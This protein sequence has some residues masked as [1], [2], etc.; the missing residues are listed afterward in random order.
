MRDDNHDHDRGLEHDLKLLAARTDRRQLLKWMMAGAALLPLVGCGGGSEGSGSACESSVPEETGGPY[1]GDGSNGANALVLSGIVRSDIRSSI[2][3]LSGT[4][5]G[6]PFTLK[7]TLVDS[8]GTCAPLEG[9]AV[10]LWHCDRDGHYSMYTLTQQ[11]YLRGVQETDSTGTVTFTSIFPACYSGRMPHLHF[12]VYPNLSTA[13]SSK[14]KI[15]T[16]QIALPT[17]VCQTVFATTGY[18]ASVSNLSRISFSSDNVFS[19][20]TQLQMATVTGSVAEGYVA[21]LTVGIPA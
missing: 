19:D 13:T 1:P 2:A 4:A 7:L 18:S 17:D 20:G 5:E 8:G 16:S 15:K 9:Y 3:G 6:V 11:N 12:E 21:T 10:Y 14:N